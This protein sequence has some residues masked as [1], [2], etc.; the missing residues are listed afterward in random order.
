MA[1]KKK[2][3]CS[4]PSP[5]WGGKR[6]GA[7]RPSR[8][9]QV[10]VREILDDAITP[11]EVMGKLRELIENGDFRAIDLYLKYRVGQPKQEMAI[12]MTGTQDINFSLNNIVTFTD[13]DEE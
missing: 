12:E 7:G 3:E 6:K 9:E 1:G 13:E 11:E 5:N 2:E 8:G 10:R 4:N